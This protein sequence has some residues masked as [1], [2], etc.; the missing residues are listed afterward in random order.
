MNQSFLGVLK[1]LILSMLSCHLI[2]YH[3]LQTEMVFNVS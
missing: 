1:L 3:E 2:N